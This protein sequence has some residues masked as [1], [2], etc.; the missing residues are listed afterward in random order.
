MHDAAMPYMQEHWLKGALRFWNAMHAS[1]NEI[2]A[3]GC[4]ADLMLMINDR[5]EAC[6]SWRLRHFMAELGDR[7]QAPVFTEPYQA[8]FLHRDDFPPNAL[9]YFGALDFNPEGA[10]DLL[11]NCWLTRVKHRGRGSTRASLPACCID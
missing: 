4:K 3:A 11:S 9:D 6:W 7:M 8:A 1:S 10:C 5:V 2:V